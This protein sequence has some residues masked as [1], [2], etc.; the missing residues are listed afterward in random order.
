MK[1]VLITG[2]ATGLGKE[3]AKLYAKDYNVILAGRNQQ[4]LTEAQHELGDNVYTMSVDIT[5]YEEVGKS[6]EKLLMQHSV[7]IL[8]NNAGI[9]HFGPLTDYTKQAIDEVIDTNV[10]GTI[11]LT[12]ALMPH[13][14]TRPEPK[15]MNIISTAG[16]RGKA[17]ESVYVASKFGVRGFTESLKVEY[18]DT[19]LHVTA[20]YMGGMNTPFWDHNN[21]IKDK[22]RLRSASEIAEIIYKQQNDSEDILF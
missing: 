11:F 4:K 18:Q 3:L 2:G 21:H 8:I 7:D 20:A 16:L 19:N 10:K 6:V 17:N 13:L 5:Q 22:S 12:Q 1:T 14:L 15:V 9:G